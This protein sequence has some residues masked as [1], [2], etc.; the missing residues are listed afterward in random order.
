MER[1]TRKTK[2]VWSRGRSTVELPFL[3]SC[4]LHL[5]DRRYWIIGVRYPWYGTRFD[6]V[7]RDPSAGNQVVLVEAKFRSDGRSVRPSEVERFSAELAKVAVASTSYFS[8]GYFMTNS[9][10][11]P[12]A[13]ELAHKL[14]IRVFPNVSLLFKLVGSRKKRKERKTQGGLDFAG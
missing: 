11:S 13:L 14:G 3:M 7:V 2:P 6:L 12:Q 9:R 4:A 1:K 5:L 8:R 10:F